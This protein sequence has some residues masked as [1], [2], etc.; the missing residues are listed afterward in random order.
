MR[1][2]RLLIN[3]LKTKVMLFATPQKRA[4]NKLQFHLDIEGKRIKEVET[5]KH[6]GVFLS[7]NFSWDSHVE[8][9]VKEGSNR[10]NGLYKVNHVLDLKQKKNL[11]EGAI[12]SRIHYAIE[13]VSSGSESTVRKLESLKSKAARYVLGKSR[14]EWSK[15]EGYQ[16]LN[17]LTVPQT[18]VEFSLR[19]FCKVLWT[20]QPEKVYKS[21]FDLENGTIRKITDESVE[22]MTKLCRKS[23]K[24]RVLRYS[25]I[26]PE[27]F[28]DVEPNSQTFKTLLKSWVK[29]NI[30]KEGD[31]IYRGK[32]KKVEDDWLRLELKTWKNANEHNLA[33]GV[34]AEELL[35]QED[36]G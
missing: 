9:I 35:E 25:S 19:L 32:K 4:K 30:P 13:V 12:L 6:L 10:L 21:I 20:R 22:G 8:E 7:N 2:N 5:A 36:Y 33:S 27:F 23:W 14:K 18:A 17:W 31:D 1:Y 29:V 3:S 11:A 26:L 16:Q 34:E 28:Y 15:T 24:I